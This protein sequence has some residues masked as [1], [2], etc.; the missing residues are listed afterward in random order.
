MNLLW[1]SDGH[2]DNKWDDSSAKVDYKRYQL[3][4]VIPRTDIQVE[5]VL[6]LKEEIEGLMYW[7]QPAKNHSTDIL[8]PPDLVLDVKQS[9]QLRGIEFVVLLKDVQV[10]R[11]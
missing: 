7:T 8:I 2:M 9:L 5:D 10:S 11:K 1:G 4:R 6:A 3:L